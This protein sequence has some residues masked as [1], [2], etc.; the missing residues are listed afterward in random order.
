[1]TY[2][3]HCADVNPSN[4][5]ILKIG[6][7]FCRIYLVALQEN[8]SPDSMVELISSF[9]RN[10]AVLNGK[11]GVAPRA[12][13][14]YFTERGFETIAVTDNNIEVINHIGNDFCA[15]IVTA[16]N[17]KNDI[18]DMIHTVCITRRE[19]GEYVIHNEYRKK[20]SLRY[21]GRKQNR[22][23]Y[24]SR[25]HSKNRTGFGSNLYYWDKSQKWKLTTRLNK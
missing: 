19:N 11:F 25:C 15:M 7:I 17:N 16:Y 14:E 4:Y 18:T 3:L 12:I 10:G 6:F 21:M 24:I 1:M 9:E 13:N 2:I 22:D 20:Y 23:V 8:V 5:Y